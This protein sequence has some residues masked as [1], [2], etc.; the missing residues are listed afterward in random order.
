MAELGLESRLSGSGALS[1]FFIQSFKV[2]RVKAAGFK[3]ATIS[4][5][6]I[7]RPPGS[8]PVLGLERHERFIEGSGP[9]R[10]N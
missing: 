9:S 10:V 7:M 3:M 4:L 8:W 6:C 5:S 1:H 2:K